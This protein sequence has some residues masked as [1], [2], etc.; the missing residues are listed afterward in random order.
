MTLSTREFIAKRA[1]M[2]IEDGNYVNLGIGIPTLVANFISPNKTVVLQSENGLL[3][4]GPYPTKDQVDPDLINAGKETVTTI[5][6]SAFFTSAESFAMIRG[7]HI[8]V[9][10][11]GGMEVSET[12]DLANWMIPGKMIKGMGGAM[13]LVHG[14]KK[15]I[16][17]MDHVA[18][19]GSPKI[20]KECTLP[21]TG[22]GVVNM[23]IT[24]RAVIEVTEQ[25]LVLK[26]VFEGHTIQ[27]VVEATEADLNV[28]NVKENVSF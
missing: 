10:I 16:V 19:D 24:D 17:I 1:E 9:A 27:G 21:L 3:G 18:K 13:D 20:K 5:P 14:A 2:E 15:I 11:L 7:G 12:G 25:G 4:I 6:G 22:K 8:D 28:E 23:I 26:E